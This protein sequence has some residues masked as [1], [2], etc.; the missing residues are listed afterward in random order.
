MASSGKSVF[1][2]SAGAVMGGAAFYFGERLFWRIRGERGSL[3][4]PAMDVAGVVA[5]AVNVQV[6]SA[7]K[8]ATHLT[9]QGGESYIVFDLRISHAVLLNKW[10]GAHLVDLGLKDKD[11]RTVW[12]AFGIRLE[13]A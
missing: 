11:G 2:L 8:S 12:F 13:E 3:R 10:F 4:Q 9:F 7:N 6:P 1:L 5:S